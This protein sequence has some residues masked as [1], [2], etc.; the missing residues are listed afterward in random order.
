MPNGEL[1]KASHLLTNLRG[2]QL[3]HDK[4]ANR[5]SNILLHSVSNWP[6]HRVVGQWAG[7][8][9]FARLPGRVVWKRGRLSFV[10]RYFDRCLRRRCLHDLGGA[11]PKDEKNLVLHCGRHV[12]GNGIYVSA[13]FGDARTEAETARAGLEEFSLYL[14]SALHKPKHIC[15]DHYILLPNRAG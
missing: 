8:N 4:T 10:V 5:Q 9:E 13:V 3:H 7:W 2:T 6:N 15:I 11:T 1:A 14:L 12:Y